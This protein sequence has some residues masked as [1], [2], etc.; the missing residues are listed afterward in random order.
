MLVYIAGVVV[1]WMVEKNN[2]RGLIKWE[3]IVFMIIMVVGVMGLIKLL[4]G[5]INVF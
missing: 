2:E 3:Y 5:R 4:M 1:Y